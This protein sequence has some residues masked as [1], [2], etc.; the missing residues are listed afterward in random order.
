L[1]TVLSGDVVSSKHFG[2]AVSAV[3]AYDKLTKGD[4]LRKQGESEKAETIEYVGNVGEKVT[5]TGTITRN[6]T[7]ETMYGFSHLVIVEGEGFIAKLF[8]TAK[9]SETPASDVGKSVTLAGTVKDH[10]EYNG[11]RQTVLTRAKLV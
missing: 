5:V 3:I 2:I 8:T 4:S 9:W 11:T 7:I 6:Q 10:N 1:H